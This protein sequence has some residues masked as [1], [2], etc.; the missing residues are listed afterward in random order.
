M[1]RFTIWSAAPHLRP[2]SGGLH[3]PSP[4]DTGAG[5][6]FQDYN[7]YIRGASPA[8]AHRPGRCAASWRGL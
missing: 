2:F 5:V 6:G 4:V 7:S 1:S 8:G 3:A